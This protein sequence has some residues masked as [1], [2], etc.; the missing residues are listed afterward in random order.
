MAKKSKEEFYVGIDIG[1]SKITTI[2]GVPEGEN[3]LRVVGVGVSNTTGLK[4]GVVNEIEETVSGISESVEIAER[5]AGIAIGEAYIN[6]NGPH[7]KS[8]NSRGVIAVGRADHEVTRDDVFRAEDAS[9]AIQMPSNRE[10]L[11]YFPRTFTLDGQEDIKDP[12]GMNGIRLEVETHIITASEPAMRTVSKCISQAGIKENG[13]VLSALASAKA[14]L[15]KRQRELG[16][17][18]IDIGAS[19]TGIC[20]FEE[21]EVFYSSVL[22]VGSSHITNDI[23]IGLRTSLDVAEKIKIKFGDANHKKVT[24]ENIDLSEIDMKEEGVVSK[25]HVAE[26][27][28]ARLFELF[29]MVQDELRKANRDGLLPAGAVLTGGGARLTNICDYAKEVLKI[30]VTIGI[31]EEVRGVTEKI[32]DP[33]YAGPIGLMMCAFEDNIHHFSVSRQLE[34]ISKR[35]KKVF[36]IFL[37]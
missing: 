20:V 9:L 2:V 12:I 28:E 31:P 23:A 34:E 11:Q 37:P 16:S 21:G 6:V 33:M 24:K 14:V 22:P 27:I 25:K 18:L 13:K 30:P 3:S 10:I 29:R 8:V 15:T 26:I 4:K 1:S 7:I 5:M 19:T 35:V 36:K 32:K 17:A